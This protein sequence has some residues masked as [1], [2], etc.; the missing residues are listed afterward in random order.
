VQPRFE[1]GQNV[2]VVRTIRNDGT[3]PG[4]EPG[5]LLVRDGS[6]GHV[7]NVGTFLQD[8]IIYAV[9]FFEV[10]RVIGCREEELIPAEEEWV[11]TLF[12]FRDKVT[13]RIPLGMNGQVVVAA[14]TEGEVLKVLRHAP[15]GPAYQVYFDGRTFLV[16]ETALDARKE[17]GDA[18]A[19]D[20]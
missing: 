4:M 18:V 5:D 6:V 2:R 9:H 1:Y 16:P 7:R 17:I 10:D 14:G 11:P 19:A 15:D 3:Y 8:N 12:L 20:A 13:A